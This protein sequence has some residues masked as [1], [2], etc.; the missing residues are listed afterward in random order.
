VTL[1]TVSCS[2][3]GSKNASAWTWE[4]GD[5]SPLDSG[6]TAQHT[7]L[8]AGDYTVTLTVT[9]L[10]GVSTD[11]DQALVTVPGP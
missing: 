5:G 1:M 9:G 4:W 11:S 6:S 10:N 2:G 3:A 7:Y 8:L